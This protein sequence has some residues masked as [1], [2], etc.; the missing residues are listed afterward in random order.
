MCQVSKYLII[1]SGR[2]ATHFGYYLKLLNLSWQQWSRKNNTVQEL[3]EYSKACSHVLLLISDQAIENFVTANKFLLTKRCVHFSGKLVVQDFFGAHPLMTFSH[4]LYDLD[5]YRSV[6]FVLEKEG[7]D[8]SELLPG[9][10]NSEYKIPRNLKSLYH[11]LIVMGNNFSTMLWQHVFQGLQNDLHLPPEIAQP[12]L[13]QT[14]INLLN[15]PQGALTGPLV[16]NDQDTIKAHLA[17]LENNLYK[18]VYRAFIEV[19]QKSKVRS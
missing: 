16:R 2:M 17:A 11:V 4:G 19:F 6:P 10:P 8:L 14:M 12:I 3:V 15:Q 1:G 9:L 18:E 13:K 5:T 7:P